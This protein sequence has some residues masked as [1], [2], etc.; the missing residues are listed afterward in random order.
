MGP[1]HI[2]T[3]QGEN[4]MWDG[5]FA[6]TISI[7][8]RELGIDCNFVRDGETAESVIETLMQ[9]MQTEHAEDWFE[10]E[11]IYQAACSVVRA[12]AA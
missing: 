5:R 12:K 1:E 4:F 3:G 10:T 7:S 2:K 9:H 8:C 6:M 11:E